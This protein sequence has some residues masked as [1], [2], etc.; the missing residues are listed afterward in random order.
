MQVHKRQILPLLMPFCYRSSSGRWLVLMPLGELYP[1]WGV[2][3]T[4]GK[5]GRP[6]AAR[7]VASQITL[8]VEP[9][10]RS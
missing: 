6:G 1:G 7:R 5:T 10:Q 2:P 9:R 8:A 3:V 4:E